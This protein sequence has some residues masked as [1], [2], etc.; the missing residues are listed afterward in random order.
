MRN[1]IARAT[2][3]M[4]GRHL[5]HGD[6]EQSTRNMEVFTNCSTSPASFL[7]FYLL[8]NGSGVGR[9]YDDDMMLV[10][11]DHAPNLRCVLDSSHA[12]FQWD[13]HESKRDAEHKYGF[14]PNVTWHVVGDSREGWAKAL[15]IWEVLAFEKIN[16]HKMLILDFSQVRK[17]GSPIGGMQSRPASGP[18]PLMGA[19]QKAASIRGAGLGRWKQAMY[20][21]HLFAECVLVGGARRAARMST[22]H[23]TDPS[24]FDFISIKRPTEFAG[25]T[26]E[27]VATTPNGGP[28][29]WSSNNS[30]TVDEKFWEL[31][32]SDNDILSHHAKKV[33][34]AIV[35]AAYG[36]GTGEP[37]IINSHKLIQKDAGWDTLIKGDFVGSDKYQIEDDTTLLFSKLAKR[38]K[39]KKHHYIV[40]PCGEIV[41]NILGGFCVIADLVP[42]H[43]DSIED[44]IDAARVT[45]R[46]LIR[47]NLMDSVFNK[48]VARTNRIGVG[49]TGVHEFAWKFFGYTFRDLLDE[50][51]SQDFWQAIAKISRAAVEESISYSTLLG[52]SAPHTVTTIKPAGTTSKLF[53]LT[54]GWHLPSMK[55]FLRWVQFRSDDLLVQTYKDLGYPI[56]ELR[57]YTGTT[58]VGFPT[59][60][61][62]TS[63]GMDDIV[64][65]SE[66]TPAEQFQWLKLGEKYW[67][68]G[69]DENSS[70]GNQ[71]SY[72]LKYHT[73]DTSFEHFKAMI[74]EHQKDVRCC[75]VMPESDATNYEY[76]P[77]QGVTKGEY[78]EILSKIIGQAAED[79]DFSHIDCA[80]GACPIDFLTG[81]KT[82]GVTA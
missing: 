23:W 19:F 59:A 7:M 75:S 24:I 74:L 78:E 25:L 77:E 52:L 43:A 5:Q 57:T 13:T 65:A 64:I 18:V 55:Q 39:K 30:V 69:G 41:L 50:E 73:N 15:E 58:I 4:S 34:N 33:F 62:I 6:A 26:M 68:N 32:K 14:G 22:K 51:K 29:L 45:T 67:I 3:L 17:K 31:Q 2:T 36:D 48:E 1:H 16:T 8:L 47:V 54:E 76:T 53:L 63:I 56:R 71:I 35:E 10:N 38:A 27:Q 82:E 11:W 60:P 80:S 37:G 66:A 40:N 72:T 61:T 12:D 49:L 42:Y 21:D 20:V 70:T 9:C 46:A 81:D 44:A 79:V 28:F